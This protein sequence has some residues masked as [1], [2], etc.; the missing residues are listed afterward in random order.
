MGIRLGLP[1]RLAWRRRLPSRRTRPL[2]G[3]EGEHRG[4]QVHPRR[5]LLFQHEQDPHRK[6]FKGGHFGPQQDGHEGRFLLGFHHE[7][8]VI[9]PSRDEVFGQARHKVRRHLRKDGHKERQLQRRLLQG[10]FLLH[11]LRDFQ[12]RSLPVGKVFLFPFILRIFLPFL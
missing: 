12:E 10:F 9:G 2:L 1:P 4:R 11:V 8:H 5:R 6:L 7:V 3:L